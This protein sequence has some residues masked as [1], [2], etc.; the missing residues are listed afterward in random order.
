MLLRLPRHDLRQLRLYGVDCQPQ[1]W[2]QFDQSAD[3]KYRITVK[4]QGNIQLG[5]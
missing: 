3:R 5:Q 4:K 2:K 1:D